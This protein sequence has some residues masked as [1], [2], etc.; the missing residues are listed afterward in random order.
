MIVPTCGAMGAVTKPAPVAL[1]MDT[2]DRECG[3][4]LAMPVGVIS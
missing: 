1:E 2:T 4:Q 3:A